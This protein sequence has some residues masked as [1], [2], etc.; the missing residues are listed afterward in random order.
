MNTAND[1]K[2]GVVK[3]SHHEHV[4]VEGE[5]DEP[6]FFCSCVPMEDDFGIPFIKA[7]QLEQISFIAKTPDSS[8][9]NSNN[10]TLSFDVFSSAGVLLTS[11][12]LVFVGRKFVHTLGTA[13]SLPAD[14]NVVVKYVSKTGTYH[15]DSRFR[16]SLQVHSLDIDA[17]V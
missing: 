12:P 15:V 4:F 16:L 17:V 14:C 3:S 1:T 5:G 10:I 13:I 9:T 7:S 6:I 2:F 8:L 11:N